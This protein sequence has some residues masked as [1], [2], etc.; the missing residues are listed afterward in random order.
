M[1]DTCPP[2]LPFADAA[3]DPA[4]VAAE[5]YGVDPALVAAEAYRQWEDNALFEL[6]IANHQ[7]LA[8]DGNWPAHVNDWE[9]PSQTISIGEALFKT[10]CD[11]SISIGSAGH[12]LGTC[13]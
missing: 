13:K 4:L 8:A 5:A 12:S 1:L 10:A 6:A 9:A 3:V 2:S 7:L 11:E